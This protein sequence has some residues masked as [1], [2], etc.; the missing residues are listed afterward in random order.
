MSEFDDLFNAFFGGKKPKKDEDK[1][2]KKN[3]D[4][5]KNF[6]DKIQGFRAD[7]SD[8]DEIANL[9]EP[10]EIEEYEEDGIKYT[11]RVWYE[12]DGIRE[13]IS[14]ELDIEGAINGDNIEAAIGKLN[15]NP[16]DSQETLEEQ[17][18]NAIA[19]EDFEKAATMRDAIE[20]RD[21]DGELF[22]NK[23]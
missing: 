10:D 7:K 21:K 16:F 14:A 8:L 12:E 15:P 17:L 18:E 9:G 2:E 3:E 4:D 13:L 5:M 20:Q 1:G 19:G 11:R 6:F 22:K 23:K